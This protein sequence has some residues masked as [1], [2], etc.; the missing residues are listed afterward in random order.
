MGNLA[1]KIQKLETQLD[2]LAYKICEV[3]CDFDSNSSNNIKYRK[4]KGELAEL[5]KEKNDLCRV[6][7]AHT[8]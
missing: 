4:L 8:Y 3:E 5:Y 6:F 7:M 1:K 2:N